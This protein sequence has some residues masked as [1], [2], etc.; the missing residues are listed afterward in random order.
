MV[1]EQQGM[2]DEQHLSAIPDITCILSGGS[3]LLIDRNPLMAYVCLWHMPVY[4]I[5]LSSLSQ[6]APGE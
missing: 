1:R 6:D 4:G 5:R 2:D 3:C